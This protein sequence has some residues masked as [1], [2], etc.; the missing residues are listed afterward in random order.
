MDA[1][2]RG[3]EVARVA[4]ISYRQLDYWSRLGALVPG[5]ADARGSGSQRL[6]SEADARAAVVL[7][8]LATH[9]APVEVMGAVVRYL[10][11]HPWLWEAGALLLVDRDGEV[12]E[13]ATAPFMPVACWVVSLGAARAAF[14]AR[15]AELGR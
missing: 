13:F 6:Y 1:P 7:S 4:G 15:R 9:L 12:E 5:V 2:W 11:Q 8:S 3:P 10:A 14:D